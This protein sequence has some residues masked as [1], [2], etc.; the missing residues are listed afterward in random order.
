MVQ[1]THRDQNKTN[2]FFLM[3]GVND[4]HKLI[5]IKGSISKATVKTDKL[6]AQSYLAYS[7]INIFS[8]IIIAK[9]KEKKKVNKK[10]TGKRTIQMY[11]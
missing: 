5:I 9:T 7:I 2:N 10:L 3:T 1:K 8:Y 4:F 6:N 11:M